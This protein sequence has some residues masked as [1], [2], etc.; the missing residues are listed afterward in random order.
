V[1]LRDFTWLAAGYMG[2]PRFHFATRYN[3]TLWYTSA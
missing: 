2:I 1:K 3:C